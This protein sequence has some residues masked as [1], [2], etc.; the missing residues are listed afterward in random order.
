MVEG[1]WRDD[2][3][4]GRG[5]GGDHHPRGEGL[6][7]LR[8]RGEDPGQKGDLHRAPGGDE[9]LP[10]V[11]RRGPGPQPRLIRRMAADLVPSAA[12]MT[13]PSSEPGPFFRAYFIFAVSGR[14]TSGMPVSPAG[15]PLQIPQPRGR[16]HQEG[17]E[18]RRHPRLQHLLGPG[19]VPLEDPG[20]S[21]KKQQVC[22]GDGD[23]VSPPQGGEVA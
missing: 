21:H 15:T 9:D 23:D 22:D 5:F 8:R 6:R 18:G 16:R 11:W 2:G 1:R 7:T 19:S 17:G 13:G 14:F 3:K 12:P 20:E 10:K 4:K